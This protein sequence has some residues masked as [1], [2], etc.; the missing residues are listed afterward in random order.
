M[1]KTGFITAA[2]LA[3]ALTACGG[4]D[5]DAFVG[6]GNGSGGSG[7]SG[8]GGTVAPASL[9]LTSV[10][11]S[12]P[13]DGSQTT[14]IRALVRDSNNVVVADTPVTLSASSGAL[15]AGATTTGDDGVA[16]A[17]L[18]TGG[19]SAPRNITVTAQ[20]ASFTA[21]V[22]VAVGTAPSSTTVAALALTTSSTSIPSD[23]TGEATIVAIAR[24]AN[25]LLLPGVPV[26]FTA[27]S[28]GLEVTQ[29]TTDNSGQAIAVLGTAGDSTTRNITVTAS[30]AGISST[31]VVG[32]AAASSGNSIRIGNGTGGSFQVNAIGI[33]PASIAAGA[34]TSLS[35]TFVR[36]DGSLHTSPVTVNFNSPCVAAG[37]AEFRVGSTVQ[38]SITTTTGQANITYAAKGCVGG[39]AVS[40]T[41]SVG[42]QSLE[43]L[44]T[45]T[46]ASA[47]VG[48]IAFVSATPANV[49][50]KGMGEASR[51][52]TS[53]VVFKV[54]DAVG[55]PVPGQLVEFALST[56]VGG[57]ELS[58]P[59][60]TSDAQGNV[61]V[62]VK[63]GTVA[64]PVRISATVVD[65]NPVIA[66]QSNALTVST[67][68]PTAGSFSLSVDRHNIEGWT[69]DGTIATVTVRLA[70][71]FS[72]PVPD[73]TPVSFQAEGGSIVAQCLTTTTPSEGGVCS[74]AL[75]S[76]NPRPIDGRISI[77]ATAIGEESFNDVNGNGVRNSGDPFTDSPEPW[78]DVNE[79]HVRDADEPFYDFFVNQNYDPVNGE[80]NG[81]LCDANCGAAKTLGISGQT[82]VIL[83]GSSADIALQTG[84][85]SMLV[86]SSQPVALWI[87]DVNGN[88][89]PAG[90]TVVVSASGGGLQVPAPNSDVVPSSALPAGVMAN[91]ITLFQYTVTSSAQ[92]GTGT[93]TITVTTPSG[94]VTRFQYG[95]TVT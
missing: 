5:E 65:S 55:G 51:P 82:V 90:T 42:S 94:I 63:A 72:N 32:V 54:T 75:R 47:S 3:L 95:I 59:T 60:A 64:T 44:G 30:T 68:I 88:P 92:P 40:A 20:S 13:A 8:G 85:P 53:T 73:G 14:E 49:A 43:A 50:L 84:N 56:T 83:S 79:N 17:T 67:G 15:S 45:I 10:L 39:D 24:D 86:S 16:K 11:A 41:A 71:R 78:L 57:I 7:G 80:F 21:T 6:G 46:V 74:V 93:L 4:G 12:I 36:Q 70:D 26:S 77:L 31:T 62:V 48:A 2:L 18:S 22:T 19:D 38:S 9:T 61:Q 35:V 69:I 87:R 25:N 23:G 1:R 52:E 34:S 29:G 81:V 58:S 66:T 91:G 33:S 76:S 27:S 28:G 89:M 37:T